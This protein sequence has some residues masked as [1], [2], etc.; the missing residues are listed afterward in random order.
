MP[1]LTVEVAATELPPSAARMMPGGPI[2]GMRYRVTVEEVEDEVAKF[3]A[4][5]D[6][7][8]AG[9]TD[10]DAGRFDDQDIEDLLAD[11]N[12]LHRAKSA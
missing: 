9:L 5:R 3:A 6:D 11:V 7:I 4:L 1:K 12:R 2:P 10:L 8:A